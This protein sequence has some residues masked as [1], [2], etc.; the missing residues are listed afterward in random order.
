[1]QN[2]L[3]P[4]KNQLKMPNSFFYCLK[5]FKTNTF[6]NF[7]ATNL[8]STA[9]VSASDY[10]APPR[11]HEN[12]IFVYEARSLASTVRKF[13]SLEAI[14]LPGALLTFTYPVFAAMVAVPTYF[15]LFNVYKFFNDS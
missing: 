2:V 4:S 9:T 7:L 3:D 8:E 14:L 15:F 5:S 12:S 13:R 11:V 6:L 1:M 10:I